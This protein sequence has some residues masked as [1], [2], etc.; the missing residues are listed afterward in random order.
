MSVDVARGLVFVP[1]TSPS[2][3]FCGG[4]GMLGTRRGDTLMAFALPR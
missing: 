1:T 2:P 4:H 3:D